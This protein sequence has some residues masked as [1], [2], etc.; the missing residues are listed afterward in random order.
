MEQFGVYKNVN[1]KLQPGEF[2]NNVKV[3]YDFKE[4]S[5]YFGSAS[6]YIDK[7][8]KQYIYR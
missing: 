1:V 3:K 7:S 5:N 4:K 6:H 2:E 8:G